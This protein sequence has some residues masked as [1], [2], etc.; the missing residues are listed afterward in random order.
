MPMPLKRVAYHKPDFYVMLAPPMRPL[1]LKKLEH[2]LARS[3]ALFRQ[4]FNLLP[5][6]AMIHSG[7]RVLAANPAAL[8]ML[9]AASRQSVVGHAIMEFVH[10]LDQAR[11]LERLRDIAHGRRAT[12]PAEIRVLT[13]RRRPRVLG[14]TS[15]FFTYKKVGAYITVAIDL[16]ERSAM[17][18]KLRESEENFRRLFEN[19][20]DVY[21]RTDKNGVVQMV[22]P[23][24][25]KVLGYEPEEIVG[26]RAEDFY[27]TPQDRDALKQALR[28]K[29]EVMDF[30]G[31]MVRKDG[32]VIDISIN[33][34]ALYDARGEFAGV[35]GIYRDITERKMLERELMRLAT[36]D[37]LTGIA[38]R[39]AFLGHVQEAL[40]RCER[41]GGRLALLLLDMDHFKSINDRYGHATGD[42]VLVRAVRV[43]Q[44]E[45]RETD[46]FGRLGGEEFCVAL[47][48]A[49]KCDA[50]AVAERICARMQ[51]LRFEHEG[52]S[53]VVSV[54]I[55]ITAYCRGDRLEQVLERADR[56]LYSAKEGGRNRASWH[57]AA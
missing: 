37:P 55:G 29:G 47:L 38:N 10:P 39:R 32:Y 23:G 42:A 6:G 28:E 8:G 2:A 43:V 41:Y 48:E 13:C 46:F 56:A 9:E 44:Q 40:S 27:P 3:N 52:V 20:S 18:A 45:L 15:M 53:F 22:G 30:P 54:S 25:R 21:Y 33:S 17:E 19:M 51:E 57:E 16:T 26:R 35:E 5:A 24:V 50:M 11:V 36:T 14:L 1:Y 49:D 12:E 7:E 34:R 31:Q 4:V